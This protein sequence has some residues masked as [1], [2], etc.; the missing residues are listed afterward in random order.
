MNVKLKKKLKEFDDDFERQEIMNA[1]KFRK[2]IEF[3]FF[4]IFWALLWIILIFLN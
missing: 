2:E 3:F 4:H 1:W